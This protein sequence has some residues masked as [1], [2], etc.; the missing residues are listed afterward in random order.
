MISCL[1]FRD[2]PF[3]LSSKFQ[4]PLYDNLDASHFVESLVTTVFSTWSV[5]RSVRQYVKLNYSRHIPL[6]K[7]YLYYK[8]KLFSGS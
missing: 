3:V 2:N 7:N 1:S 5:F 8:E 6:D 4:V